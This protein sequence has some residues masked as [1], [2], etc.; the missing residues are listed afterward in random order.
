MAYVNLS[1]LFN[2]IP[3]SINNERDISEFYTNSQSKGKGWDSLLKK[4]RVVILAEAGSGK[5]AEIKE[6]SRTLLKEGE[7]SFFLRLEDIKDNFDDAFDHGD[8]SLFS[9]WLSGNEVGYFFLD[10]VDEAKLANE[11]DF[12]KALRCFTKRINTGKP[13]AKIFLTSRGSSWRPQTDLAFV[14]DLLSITDKEEMLFEVYSFSDLS[15]EQVLLFSKEQGVE[16]FNELIA[17]IK[18]ND[19]DVFTKRPLDLIE[20]IEYW[21]ANSRIGSRSELLE[22][23]ISAKLETVEIG[24]DRCELTSARVLEGVLEL[25]SALTFCKK[26]KILIPDSGTN[27]DGLSIQKVLPDWTVDEITTLLSRPIFEP[28]IYGAVRFSHRLLREYLTAKWVDKKFHNKSFSIQNIQNLFYKKIYDVE[29]P[30]LSLKPVLAWFVL[31]NDEFSGIV[32]ELSPELFIEGGDPSK[33]PIK[34]REDLLTRFCELYGD[35]ENCFISFDSSA[36]SRFGN[37]DMGHVTRNLLMTYSLNKDLRQTLLQLA[38]TFEMPECR[39]ISELITKDADVDNLSRILSVRLLKKLATPDEIIK[40]AYELLQLSFKSNNEDIESLILDEYGNHISLVESINLI[41][42]IKKPS[43][44]NFRGIQLSVENF[45]K[46]LPQNLVLDVVDAFYE[47]L[48]ALPY[49]KGFRCLVSERNEWLFPSIEIAILR[50]LKTKKNSYWTYNVI[51]MIS[52]AQIYHK[53]GGYSQPNEELPLAIKECKQ[54]SNQLFWHDVKKERALNEKEKKENP[55]RIDKW[56]QVRVYQEFWGFDYTD[57]NQVFDWVYSKKLRDDKSIAFSLAW[58]LVNENGKDVDEIEKLKLA[59]N[60]FAGGKEIL[61]L[62]LNPV[63]EDWQVEADARQIEYSK[64]REEDES[65]RQNNLSESI[66]LIK[67]ESETIEDIRNAITGRINGFQSYLFDYIRSKSENN[68]HWA[69][70]NWQDLVPEFGS[71]VAE[72]YKC[73]SYAYWRSYNAPLLVSEGNNLSSATQGFTFALSGV[74]IEDEEVLNWEMELK[75][76]EIDVAVKL[77]LCEMNGL[78]SWFEK[79]FVAYPKPVIALLLKEITWLSDDKGEADNSGYILG[80]ILVNGHYLFDA[81]SNPLLE[82]LNNTSSLKYELIKKILRILSSSKYITDERLSNLAQYK[83]NNESTMDNSCLWWAILISSDAELGITLF[84]EQL[85]SESNENATNLAMSVITE[86]SNKRSYDVLSYRASHHNVGSIVRLY[87]LMHIYIREEDDTNRANRGCYSPT[88][89]DD[90]QDARNNLFNTLKEIPGEDTYNALKSISEMWIGDLYRKSWIEHLALQRAKEDADISCFSETQFY[91][92]S[93]QLNETT[94][95]T[96]QKHN[97]EHINKVNTIHKTFYKPKPDLHQI[98][99]FI[100]RLLVGTLA[101]SLMK[102][103]VGLLTIGMWDVVLYMFDSYVL[104]K[105]AAPPGTVI[106]W[107]QYIAIFL[108]ILGFSIKSIQHFSKQNKNVIEQ[109]IWLKENFNTLTDARLQDEF[110]RLFKVKDADI[111]AIKNILDHPYN[112]NKVIKLFSKSHMNVEPME[113][114]FKEKGK[115]LKLRGNIALLIWSIFPILIMFTII[116]V[117]AEYLSPGITK[118]GTY[119]IQAYLVLIFIVSIGAVSVL[120]DVKALKHAINLVRNFKP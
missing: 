23:S 38:L 85:K 95:D 76:S 11:R 8:I 102:I 13:R 120:N 4:S 69:C 29:V 80:Q 109:K 34:H 101:G 74:G 84:G 50:L 61:E 22:S 60:E 16:N 17:E 73:A 26:S 24:R 91:N 86:L 52:R 70:L 103:G 93:Q 90:A 31:F 117:I 72:K 53:S 71:E 100:K 44:Y 78:P 27:S 42:N 107:P 15:Y 63:K 39:E 88:L 111:R 62:Y 96:N 55:I 12:H 51:E 104:G 106:E 18:I 82:I 10:S 66:K 57:L 2:E 67:N 36:I 45:I 32:A 49:K 87:Q 37:S 48:N 6:Q 46:K 43:K 77:A 118:S 14:N 9:N 28:S 1:R 79:L 108:F 30:V 115:Y 83:L 68:N 65:I 112:K 47:L 35:K 98:L 21:K 3:T 116:L 99:Q 33:I 94:L 59:A 20:L 75:E 114:W 64:Q 119:A 7:Y 40:N 19:A 81:I 56:Y 113:G 97:K 110:E 89:R 58:A 105:Q 5:T 25:A 41:K 54:L 92:Y